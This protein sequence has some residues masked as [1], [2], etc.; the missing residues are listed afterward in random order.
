SRDG[1]PVAV[2][3]AFFAIA[4]GTVASEKGLTFI[5]GMVMTAIV[6]AGAS[7]FMALQFWNEPLPF[8]TIVLVVLAVNF[9]HVLYGASISRKLYNFSGIQKF[10][11][12]FVLTDPNFAL[13]ERRHEVT[14]PKSTDPG[15][16]PDYYFGVAF[17]IF[18]FWVVAT[19]VGLLFGNLIEDPDALGLEFILALYFML[20][21][22]GF[23]SRANWL[24][25]VLVSGVASTL[26]YLTLGSPWHI[27]A[28]AL[29]GVITG[30]F[31]GEPDAAPGNDSRENS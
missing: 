18:T 12:F 26:V 15:L 20:L 9:R 10:F 11:M 21:L 19:G 13:A 8:V 7:Q 24:P 22:L 25:V 17:P 6:F 5:E 28:G 30:A 2:T 27:S 14:E 16:T 3:A 4:F 1:L 29:C 31:L 23:R